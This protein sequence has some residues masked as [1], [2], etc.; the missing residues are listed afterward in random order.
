MA[1]DINL[2]PLLFQE[3]KMKL[4]LVV[5]EIEGYDYK[6]EGIF[7]SNDFAEKYLSEIYDGKEDGVDYWIESM[8]LDEYVYSQKMKYYL[9]RIS[10]SN[11]VTEGTYEINRMSH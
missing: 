1:A 10:N 7:S 8:V 3:V 5:S 2:R 4:Y 11:G 6:I 9:T